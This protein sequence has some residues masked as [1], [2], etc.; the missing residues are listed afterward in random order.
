MFS[1]IDIDEEDVDKLEALLARIFHR[2]KGNFKGKLPTMCFNCNEV[3]HIAA[4]NPEK[5]N[6]R[7][8]DKYKSRRDEDSKDY[9][10]KGK[11]SCYIVEEDVDQIGALLARR[12]HWGKGKFKGK[13]PIM[14][15]NYNEVNHIATRCPEKKNYRGGDKYKSR[16]DEDNKD[17][18]DKG[19][20]SC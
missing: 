9:K 1:D 7:G 8:G 14:C 2:G 12:F 18:K 4:R 3:S 19:N 5:K 10:D 17:Y 6:Y 15:F 13:L 16:R 20:K 11:K